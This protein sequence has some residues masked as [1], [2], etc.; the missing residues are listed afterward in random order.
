MPPQD[1]AVESLSLSPRLA[2]EQILHSMG[3]HQETRVSSRLQRYIE[4]TISLVQA[5]ARP[6]LAWAFFE[7]DALLKRLPKSRRLAKYLQLPER[8]AVAAGTA[9]REWSELVEETE[10]A[11]LSYLYSCAA[12]ALA[13]DALQSARRELSQRYPDLLIG[14]SLSPGTD[15]LPF[16]FQKVLQSFGILDPI[17]VHLDPENLFMTPLAS[18]TAFIGFGKAVERAAPIPECGAA[19]PR[20][21]QCPCRNCSL[22]VLP[23]QPEIAPLG[24]AW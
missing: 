12:T 7:R 14:D 9:G 10:D 21:P 15:G 1:I 24:V 23:Y 17:G 22:R 3:G 5:T 20:C 19:Q 13:R 11:F 2:A 16:S 18:V 8:C 6:K 4:E